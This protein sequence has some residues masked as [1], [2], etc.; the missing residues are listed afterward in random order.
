MK[1]AIALLHIAFVK[2]AMRY[3]T[4]R[5]EYV[6]MLQIYPIIPF[7]YFIGDIYGE[8]NYLILFVIEVASVYFRLQPAEE[9]RD[10]SD[11]WDL[12]PPIISSAHDQCRTSDGLRALTGLGSCQS[13]AGNINHC[14]LLPAISGP[15]SLL[16]LLGLGGRGWELGCYKSISAS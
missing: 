13:E 7:L 15:T 11:D 2:R 14:Y 3:K 5:Y 6:S 9:Q 10:G 1:I 4:I 16:L 8:L 12:S